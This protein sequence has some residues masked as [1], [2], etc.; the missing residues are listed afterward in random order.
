MLPPFSQPKLNL[1]LIENTFSRRNSI[2]V[3]AIDYFPE[4]GLLYIWEDIKERALSLIHKRDKD[5]Y[6]VDLDRN[7]EG[8][9]TATFWKRGYRHPVARLY[10][11]K[12]S[13]EVSVND[14][15]YESVVGRF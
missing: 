7:L 2:V 10:V 15:T 4:G 1:V 13:P 12:K 3:D 14:E 8:F 9:P 11:T 5:D 6:R